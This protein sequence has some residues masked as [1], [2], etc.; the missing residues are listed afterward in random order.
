MRNR[1]FQ[2]GFISLNFFQNFCQ[3]LQLGQFWWI[4]RSLQLRQFR[5]PVVL[6]SLLPQK[7]VED[8]SSV[9]A[10]AVR[11]CSPKLA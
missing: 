3:S 1:C 5:R 9:P 4:C 8:C 2:K 11:G 7:S 10:C 6:V